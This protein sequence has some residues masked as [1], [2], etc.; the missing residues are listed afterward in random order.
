MISG[1]FEKATWY[2]GR[3]EL[4]TEIQSRNQRT[5]TL[6]IRLF[7]VLKHVA[8]TTDHQ[9]QAAVGMVIV[10]VL[11]QV[12]VQVIDSCCQQSNLY[13]RGACVAF[14]LRVSGNNFGFVHGYSSFI[15]N[16]R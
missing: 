2:R 9:Q 3:P 16:H 5:V 13:F 12:L 4:F 8:A 10:L 14:M 1:G 11:L 6:N 7:Q 15:M